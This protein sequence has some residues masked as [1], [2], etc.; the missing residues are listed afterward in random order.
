MMLSPCFF[1]LLLYCLLSYS[2]EYSGDSGAAKSVYHEIDSKVV[3]TVG[4][5]KKT[6]GLMDKFW[7][8][9]YKNSIDNSQSMDEAGFFLPFSPLPSIKH[10]N[11]KEKIKS[12]DS[13]S[14]SKESYAQTYETTEE[15]SYD[16]TTERTTTEF[17]LQ[18]YEEKP[19]SSDT[20]KN[21]DVGASSDKK[22]SDSMQA[23]KDLFFKHQEEFFQHPTIDRRVMIKKD[24]ED[25]TQKTK[26]ESNMDKP[27]NKE[28]KPWEKDVVIEKDKGPSKQPWEQDF[29]RFSDKISNSE[30]ESTTKMEESRRD[31]KNFKPQSVENIDR[32]SGMFDQFRKSLDEQNQFDKTEKKMEVHISHDTSIKREE[33]HQPKKDE[34]KMVEQESSMKHEPMSNANPDPVPISNKPVK[35]SKTLSEQE[36]QY[37]RCPSKP[38]DTRR[39]FEHPAKEKAIRI[40]ELGREMDIK[41]MLGTPSRDHASSCPRDQIKCSD[42]KYRS[43]EGVC[44]HLKQS[45]LGSRN[46]PYARLI[47]PAYGG[48]YLP[49]GVTSYSEESGYH[50]NLPSPRLISER[51]CVEGKEDETE[52]R[53]NT[54]MMMQWGQFI[55]HDMLSTSGSAFD[56]CDPSIRNL[57]RCFPISVPQ[58]DQWYS[59]FRKTCLD[60]TRSNT[61]CDSGKTP[62]QFNTVTAFIDGSAVYGC[63]EELS[64]ILRGGDKRKGGEL[65]GNSQLPK[66]LPSKFDLRVRMGHGEKVTDFVAGDTR[67][68]TQA[69]LTA[70]QNLFFNEHN[71]IAQRLFD[72]LKDTIP[73]ERERD[74]FVFQET[75]KIVSA[76]IQHITYNEFLPNILGPEHMSKHHLDHEVCEYDEQTDPTILNSFASAAWRFGHSLVQSIFRGKNQPW[77]LGKF[78]ADSHFAFKDN[79]HGYVNELEGLADQPCQKADLHFSGQLTRLLFCNNMTEP[80]G[81]HD[82]VSTNIQRGRDHGIPSYNEYRQKCGMRKVPTMAQ[83]PPEIGGPEWDELRKVYQ[84]PDQIDLYIGGLAETHVPGGVVGPTFACIIGTQ[85]QRLM[86]GDRYF[87]RHTGG[88]NI[89]PL[90]GKILTEVK[91][92]RL[93]DIICECTDVTELSQNVIKRAGPLSNPKTPCSSHKKMNMDDIINE[94]KNTV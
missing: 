38:S 92:R 17:L 31:V 33:E 51:I 35:M 40:A 87:Y 41:T 74:E 91:K 86:D 45:H 66:F 93:S 29:D 75:R 55:D 30:P 78:Y 3:P 54:H 88:P 76:E 73:D 15:P 53:M 36:A 7:H 39:M 59:Q 50:S 77:R 25:E 21:T 16:K 71:R 11:A 64:L 1:I 44:N 69:S 8:P 80:G 60:F 90:K 46:T 13:Y 85:F 28:Q 27:I 67:V 68:E 32:G 70:I 24:P 62:E 82:L 5:Q 72:G 52:S 48:F 65:F 84:H 43:F 34:E 23:G 61:H 22:S 20:N 63:H 47:S 14:G 83:G 94:L 4:P 10:F 37:A 49:R 89:Q 19:E 58:D 12:P 6:E 56:C 2:L 42:S 26:S 81:G 57:P 9:S 18:R 79:G